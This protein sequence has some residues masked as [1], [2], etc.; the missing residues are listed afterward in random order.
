MLAMG[1]GAI[2]SLPLFATEYPVNSEAALAEAIEAHNGDATAEIV[3]A[4]KTYDLAQITA[5]ANGHL[6]ITD[7]TLRGASGDPKDVIL[8]G[9]DTRRIVYGTRGVIRDLTISHGCART[10][11]ETIVE[12][13]G[14]YGYGD[15]TEQTVVSNVVIT[16][17]SAQDGG[18]AA[19]VTGYDLTVVDNHAYNRGGGTFWGT[20]YDSIITNNLSENTGG[21]TFRGTYDHCR[22]VGNQAKSNGGGTWG[23]TVRNKSVLGY[24]ECGG[25]GAGGFKALVY[26]SDIVCNVISKTL[27][28]KSVV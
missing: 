22:I 8:L 6:A 11:C 12:G 26:S 3:L 15:S 7:L 23:G 17:C 13:G 20:Y 1:V 5:A 27:D 28:R 4:A 24:N 2:C 10:G 9:N 14:V 25:S 18:G 16:G 21:G 19:R